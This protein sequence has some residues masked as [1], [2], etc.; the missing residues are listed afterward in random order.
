MTEAFLAAKLNCR[1]SDL[2]TGVSC[3][4]L[5][6]FD[7]KKRGAYELREWIEHFIRGERLKVEVDV[8]A[9]FG[10][11]MTNVWEKVTPGYGG[12]D[13]AIADWA[14]CF[15]MTKSAWAPYV[16]K[17][18]NMLRN[19][20]ASST[21][22]FQDYAGLRLAFPSLY[23]PSLYFWIAG[24]EPIKVDMFRSVNLSVVGNNPENDVHL[25]SDHLT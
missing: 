1:V 12:V 11:G 16:T 21:I 6:D 3:K 15:L 14:N 23:L 8:S 10:K 24:F 13:A 18:I 20:P 19:A 2:S 7:A 5:E 22:T 4:C 17:T 25:I 9:S